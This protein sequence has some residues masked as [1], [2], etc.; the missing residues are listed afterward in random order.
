MFAAVP[1]VLDVL[2]SSFGFYSYSRTL[3]FTTGWLLGSIGFL[4][5]YIP[6]ENLILNKNWR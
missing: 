3:A 4:Y 2:F 6:L 5:F 1:L